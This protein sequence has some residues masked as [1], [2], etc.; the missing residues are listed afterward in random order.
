MLEDQ[1]AVVFNDLVNHPIVGINDKIKSE[2]VSICVPHGT[3][4][5]EN[6]QYTAPGAGVSYSYVMPNILQCI[7]ND[8]YCVSTLRA[9][10]FNKHQLAEAKAWK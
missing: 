3:R 6:V 10:Y 9:N 2:T 8:S 4:R 1:T 7:D 5:N